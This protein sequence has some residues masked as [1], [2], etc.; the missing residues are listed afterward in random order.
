MDTGQRESLRRRDDVGAG[1]HIEAPDNLHTDEQ[2]QDD[3]GE[4]GDE[5]Y[6]YE[7]YGYEEYGGNEGAAAHAPRVVPSVAGERASAV[8]LAI[9][10]WLHAKRQ[11]SQSAKT[12]AAYAPTLQAFRAHMRAHG[13]DLDAVD[14][15]IVRRQLRRAAPTTLDSGD[16]ASAPEEQV[17]DLVAAHATSIA[18]LAQSFAARPRQTRDGP[19]PV[20]PATIKARLAALSSFYTYA[21]E[22]DLL[23][24]VNPIARL[25]RP[26][27]QRY[28]GAAPLP[29][30]YVD[31]RLRAIDRGTPAGKR[32]YA[33]IALGLHTGRRLSELAGLRWGHITTRAARLEIVWARAKGG[34]K[35]VDI[36]PLRGA[37][38]ECGLALRE[39]M[40]HAYPVGDPT[41]H[42][43][44]TAH[45]EAPVWISLARN[46]TAGH[47]LSLSAIAD[48]CFK[49]LSVSTVHSLRHTFARGMEDTGA[50][51]SEIQ[52]HLG[53]ES[54]ETTGR[55]LA[56]LSA[57]ENRHLAHLSKL[58]G[59][60]PPAGPAGPADSEATDDAGD[61]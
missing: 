39:W 33:L 37:E 31:E 16:A 40:D 60:A 52:A 19:R 17:E 4:E 34:K 46:G 41:A 54:L 30:T 1:A 56:R 11:L 13:L 24:G 49:R 57:G 61:T 20:S 8:E 5:E 32:D 50:K 26:K 6:G 36:L 9:A 58:F 3:A 51:V 29:Y 44:T 45:A 42:A 18:L 2:A 25:K 15:R 47:T 10:A 7:E 53:H 12:L 27:T 14:P 22:Q 28:A 35:M 43:L 23:R 59:M 38:R 21:L 55:Y 48:I